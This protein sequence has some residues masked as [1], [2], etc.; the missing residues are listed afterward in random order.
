[1]APQIFVSANPDDWAKSDAYHNEF[2]IPKDD[3]LEH[4]LKNSVENGLPE[5]QVSTAQGK[6]LNLSARSI[7]AKRILE[8]GTLGGYSTIW[9]GR[10]LPVDGKLITLEIS[11]KH[12]SVAREN[13]Q[14]AGLSDKVE[15]KIGPAAETLKTLQPDELFDFVFI[16]ADKPGNLAY[17]LQA[18]RLTRKGA[19]IIVDNV[20]RGGKVALEPE[21]TEDA[22]VNGI[23]KLL[24]HLKG[25][26][27]VDATTLGL[28]GEKGYDGI[29]YSIRL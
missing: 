27:E 8:V 3:A 20:V 13:I 17:F 22:N 19:I 21:N 25:D 1:M 6:F 23:R 9:L 14:R 26:K 5:I 15:T 18:K 12:A 29:L 10:A 24:E 7:G 16:D 2:L 11:E 28:A 4:A